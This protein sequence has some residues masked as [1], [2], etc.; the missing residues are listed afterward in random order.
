MMNALGLQISCDAASPHYAKV[1]AMYDEA[2]KAKDETLILL[3][4]KKQDYE[5]Y[6]LLL[7]TKNGTVLPD[8]SLQQTESESISELD[9]EVIEDDNLNSYD[10]MSTA[11]DDDALAAITNSE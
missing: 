6:Q 3:S 10:D 8:I 1:Q 4:S 2:S 7:E 5:A 9:A 11:Y